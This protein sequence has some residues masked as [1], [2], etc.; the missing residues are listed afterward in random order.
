MSLALQIQS[1]HRGHRIEIEDQSDQQRRLTYFVVDGQVD[2]HMGTRGE[3]TGW[4][5]GWESWCQ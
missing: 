4:M 5:D 2:T 3:L 1:V